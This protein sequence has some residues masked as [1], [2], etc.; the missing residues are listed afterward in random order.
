MSFIAQKKDVPI[1]F[2]VVCVI[3]GTLISAFALNMIIIPAGLLSGGVTGISQIIKHFIPINVGYFYFILNI[4][5]MILGYKF[6]GKKF[7]IYTIL[8][9][10]LVSVFLVFIPIRPILTNNILLSAIFGG[11]INMIGSAIVLRFG[12]SQGGLDIPSRIIAKYKNISVGKIN[13]I[14]NLVIVTISGFIFGS[15]IALYTIISMTFSMKTS[16]LILNHV[17]RITLLIITDKGDEVAELITHDIH[18]GTTSW[19]A[20]GGYTH[21]EKTVLFCVIVKGELAQL[22]DIVKKADP[23][24]FVSVITT[25]NVIGRFHQIW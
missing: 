1:Y 11:V 5:L 24:A 13:L 21:K 18:R 20:S 17:N 2:E 25:Q 4:P 8:S 9:I 22:K 23:H 19:Q 15:E 10:T 12:G 3:L 16:D 14:I 6:L 7:S